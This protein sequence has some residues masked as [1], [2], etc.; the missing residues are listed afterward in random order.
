MIHIAIGQQNNNEQ[1]ISSFPW[2]PAVDNAIDR[3]QSAENYIHTN[4]SA[5][6]TKVSI[7]LFT[8]NDTELCC[9]GDVMSCCCHDSNIVVIAT[10]TRL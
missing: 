7:Y 10:I 1:L 5:E 9:H 2:Q 3:M 8:E 4:A 6:I